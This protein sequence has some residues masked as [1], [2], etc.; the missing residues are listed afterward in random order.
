MAFENFLK[1]FKSLRTL[2]PTIKTIFDVG[3]CQ[4]EFSLCVSSQHEDLEFYLF[5]ANPIYDPILSKLPFRYFINLL[6]DEGGRIREFYN[7]NN[8]GDSYYK[9]TTRIYD[10]LSSIK[11]E[12]STLFELIDAERL[13]LP[14]LIK[15]DTQGSEIDVLTGM[16]A[17]LKKV[18][19]VLCEC[20]ILNYNQGAP[21]FSEYINF[22]KERDFVPI[23]LIDQH[24]MDGIAVQVDILF[25]HI[26]F[27]ETFLGPVKYLRPFL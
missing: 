24:Y 11:L 25:A 1:V 13:P 15:L 20:P 19:L 22:F 7:G 4:G 14:D 27:K 17:F 23:R 18:K 2:D 3:A 21:N 12:T 6:S 5:E 8:T 26:S 9:E 10:S 16:G